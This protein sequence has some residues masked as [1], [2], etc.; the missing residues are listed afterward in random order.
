MIHWLTCTVCNPLALRRRRKH[1]ERALAEGNC[2]FFKQ[3]ADASREQ[4]RG[5]GD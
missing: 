2:V 4:R 1:T 3:L 5:A